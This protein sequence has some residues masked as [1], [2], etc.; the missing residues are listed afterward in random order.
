MPVFNEETT[1]KEIISKV[2][3]QD[4]V[5]DLIVVD[6]ASTDKTKSILK[7]ISNNSKLKIIYHEKNLGKG[8]AIRS[9]LSFTTGKFTIIQDADL[10]YDPSE[11]S[12]LLD[13]LINNQAD[14]VFGSRFQSGEQR[15]VLYFWHY[16]GNRVLTT[17]SN[18]FTN[19]NLT[20]METC[21]KVMRTEILQSLDLR[22]NG[23]GIEPEI[24]AK[25]S[26]RN[27][28]IYEVGISYFGR[29]YLDGKKITWRDGF[30]ALYCIVKYNIFR[31]DLQI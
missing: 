9:A 22:E 5:K 2:F 15:R 11:Y 18:I 13:P 26:K 17:F 25:I 8:A 31:K 16:I 30:R 6:D 10:E 14:I 7:S 4:C 23:F 12:K 3:S 24:T 29:T 19:V 20:D 21:F 1:I 27:F 28:R